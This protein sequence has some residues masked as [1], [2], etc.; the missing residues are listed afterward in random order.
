[1]TRCQK[2]RPVAAG[3]KAMKATYHSHTTVVARRDGCRMVRPKVPGFALAIWTGVDPAYR[4]E[5]SSPEGQNDNSTKYF[6]SW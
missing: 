2:S 6:A 3:A 4:F 1:M 5:G